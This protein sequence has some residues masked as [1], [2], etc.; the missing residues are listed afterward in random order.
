MNRVLK[1]S[2][3]III[4]DL[5]FANK[6]SRYEFEYHCSTR[7]KDDL[8]DEFFANVDEV[9]GILKSYGYRCNSEQIDDLI[10]MVVAER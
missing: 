1:N 9:E 10:W 3:R 4:T 6:T 5:M 8:E 2:G 7:E